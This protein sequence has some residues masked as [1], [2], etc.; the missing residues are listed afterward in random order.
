MFHFP[1]GQLRQIDIE[2]GQPGT[3]PFQ[4]NISAQ[5]DECQAHYEKL[6]EAVTNYVYHLLETQ[7]NL[8]KIP[9]PKDSR[10]GSFIFVSDDYDTKNTLVILIHGS[11]V[12]RA[13]QWARS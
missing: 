8:K 1:E 13:G 12:V 9:V 2:N 3:K 4:F 5:H 10:N 6:G 7:V 11:G